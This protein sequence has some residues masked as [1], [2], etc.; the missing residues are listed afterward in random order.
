MALTLL[1][2]ASVDLVAQDRT[3]EYQLKAVLL[4]RLMNFI[5]WPDASEGPSRF[6]VIGQ[7][8]FGNELKTVF[9]ESEIEIEQLG[10][11]FSFVQDCDAVFIS[12]SEI[13]NFESVLDLLADQPILTIS[14]MPR[15]ALSGGMINLRFENRRVRFR[16]NK[17]EADAANLQLSFQLLDLAD[18]VQTRTVRR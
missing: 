10:N 4:S 1:S 6:C 18:I 3:E 13:R 2:V 7:N 12:D 17:D 5:T 11:Q 15:F 8:P 9:A 16:I 14:D